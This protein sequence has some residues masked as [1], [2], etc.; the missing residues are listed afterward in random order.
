[1][2]TNYVLANT[3]WLRRL[4]Q[5]SFG[6]W[7]FSLAF[8]KFSGKKCIYIEY[9]DETKSNAH[10]VS[11][12]LAFCG[13]PKFKFHIR[14]WEHVVLCV[15]P[16]LLLLLLSCDRIN[17]PFLFHSNSKITDANKAFHFVWHALRKYHLNLPYHSTL[18]MICFTSSVFF[19][20]CLVYGFGGENEKKT[21]V[22]NNS[23]KFRSQQKTRWS[24]EEFRFVIKY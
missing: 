1:M 12:P 14:Y 6:I 5:T 3:Q 11:D 10:F 19:F 18:C 22:T 24:F 15:R 16:L 21:R 7:I 17:S 23:G 8:R 2:H 9:A 4:F 20:F 13:Q